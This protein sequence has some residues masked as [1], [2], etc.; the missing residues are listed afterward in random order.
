MTISLRAPDLFYEDEL[1]SLK[2]ENARLKAEVLRLRAHV[3]VLMEKKARSRKADEE[4]KADEDREYHPA[5]TSDPETSH[6]AA[7]KIKRK[8]GGIQRQV[9]AVLRDAYP[10]ALS[11]DQILERAE[12]RF[13]KKVSSTWRTRRKELVDLGLVKWSDEKTTN[14]AGSLVRTWIWR[15]DADTS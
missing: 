6:I 8:L 3:E 10:A 5:R 7:E 4:D 1:K 2:D 12:T 14:A 11:D 9:L 13:G 15:P